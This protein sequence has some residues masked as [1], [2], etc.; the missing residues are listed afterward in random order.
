VNVLIYLRKSREDAEKEKRTGED[1]LAVH[2]G[3]LVSLC[4]KLGHTYMTREEV[5]SGDTIS[6]RPEFQKVLYEDMPSGI[7]QAIA[8]NEIPRLSRGNM[9]DAGIIYESIIEYNIKI[10]TPHKIYNPKN[11]SDLRQLR[12][13]LFL[14]REEF[15]T[16]RDRLEDGRDAAA[17]AGRAAN[18]IYT[19]G[20]KTIRGDYEIDEK[21]LEIARLIYTMANEGKSLTGIADYLNS[22]GHRTARGKLFNRKLVR[23]VLKNKHYE[24]FQE[25]KGEI[26][27]AQHGPLLPPDLIFGARG[28]LATADTQTSRKNLDFWAPL[29]CARCG[30]KMHGLNK[31]ERHK[32]KEYVYPSY[33]CDGRNEKP[34]CYNRA[35]AKRVHNEIE[36]ALRSLAYD[37]SIQKELLQQREAVDKTSVMTEYENLRSSLKS[38]D[39]NKRRIKADYISGALDIGT[40]N[41]AKRILEGQAKAIQLR[42]R[43]L[44]PRLREG[45]KTPR[46]CI[47]E[48]KISMDEW[49]N[50]PNK[51]K[52]ET[53]SEFTESI[54]F[55]NIT[56]EL[57]IKRCLP[58]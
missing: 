4:K 39:D 49:D 54:T 3:R 1:I 7:Y 44:E 11:R 53:V 48:L 5:V 55:N 46:Q 42:M 10:I 21:G 13:E 30:R 38:N 47:D 12:F 17:K 43:E 51:V 45:K 57:T 26:Y 58:L 20:L 27:R 36:I 16:I 37:K 23:Q 40:Y 25:W 31:K 33:L 50:L 24:G 32:D 9:Q 15:E 41:D 29:T 6:G 22:M 28:K 2:R 14:S 52:L 35:P 56:K 34:S 19:L 18:N 8:V